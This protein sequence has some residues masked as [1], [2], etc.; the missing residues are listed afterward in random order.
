M[1]SIQE[2][3]QQIKDLKEQLAAAR[4]AQ[5]RTPVNAYT[6]A[7]P[8]GSSV[9]FTELFGDKPDLI[10]IHNMGRKCP[11]CTLWADGFNGSVPH[12]T[13]RAAFVLASPD[14]YDTMRRFAEGRG[15]KFRVVSTYGT[16]FSKDLGYEF[17]PG[18]YMPG[19]SAFRKGADGSVVRTG[20]ASFGPG[21]D[22]CAVWPLFSLLA[23]G[24]NGWEPKYSY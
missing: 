7:N 6:L 17:K 9:D 10:L 15:W 3:E 2:L 1:P 16:T 13:N 20:T 12:L 19:V 5:P 24:H 14:D 4:R 18:E 11:Y 8:D 21:D 23:N 22:F